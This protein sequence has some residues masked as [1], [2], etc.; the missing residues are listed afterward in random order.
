MD[1]LQSYVN[2][3][4][5]HIQVLVQT[6]EDLQ[7]GAGQNHDR[8]LAVRFYKWLYLDTDVTAPGAFFFLAQ[9]GLTRGDYPW[10]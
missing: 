3:L 1:F 6:I 7:R 4:T 8:V 2:D 5:D 10:Q 9:N